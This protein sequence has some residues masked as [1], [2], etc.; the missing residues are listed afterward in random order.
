MHGKITTHA[1]IFFH[2][3]IM[4]VECGADQLQNQYHDQ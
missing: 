3:Q 1:I 4:V 2:R